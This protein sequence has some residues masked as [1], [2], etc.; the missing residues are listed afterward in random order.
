MRILII[1]TGAIGGFL[2]A[3]FIEAG[4]EVYFCDLKADLM[5][6]IILHGLVIQELDGRERRFFPAGTC[7]DPTQLSKECDLV[8]FA[9]KSYAT[10]VAAGR[11]V[12][13]RAI[14][15]DT[16]IL[17][18]QN[19]L[20]NAEILGDIFGTERLIVGT[21]A[22][23]ATLLE[24]GIVRHGGVGPTF[25]GLWKSDREGDA[26][27]LINTVVSLF[28]RAG[29][30]IH[31]SHDVTK[32]IWEKLL[33]NVG[34][35]AITAITGIL[36][37]GVYR[38]EPAKKVSRKAVQEALQVAS[39]LGIPL[40]E[41]IEEHVLKVAVATGRNRSSMGQDV[42]RKHRTEI[43]AINGAIVKLGEELGVETPINWTLTNLVKTLELSY[44]ET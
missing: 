20:G 27:D 1:G 29:L 2:G 34:I 8:L 36:N 16:I 28:I 24:P 30:E 41:D 44:M 3:R 13:S 43:D 33:V 42:D 15:K 22:Q 9:V 37:E 39:K 32:L 5:E 19:G 40:R 18:L 11:A 31:V 4:E 26:M 10:K 25:V 21:T 7:T 14:T 38:Y 23:G 12:L 35:N 17:T 6:R